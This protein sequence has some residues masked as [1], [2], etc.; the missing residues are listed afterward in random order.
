[1]NA[2]APRHDG[3][4]TSYQDAPARTVTAGGVTFAYRELGPTGGV[5]VVFLVHLAANLDNWDPGSSTRSPSA[6]T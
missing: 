6:T 5:P 3:T 4:I 1:M 2:D